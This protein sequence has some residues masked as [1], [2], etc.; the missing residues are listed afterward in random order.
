[1]VYLNRSTLSYCSVVLEG[2]SGVCS[3]DLCF[4]V[5][6]PLVRAVTKHVCCFRPA[7]LATVDIKY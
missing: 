6:Q 4:G 5:G 3:S 7:G 2:V 1:M